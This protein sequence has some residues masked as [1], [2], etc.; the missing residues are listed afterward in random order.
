MEATGI[1][2]RRPHSRLF[3]LS[4]YTKR[5]AYS[6][7]ITLTDNTRH[8]VSLLRERERERERDLPEV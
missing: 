2:K 5:E 8:Y 4:S 7:A 6:Y 1:K 3:L